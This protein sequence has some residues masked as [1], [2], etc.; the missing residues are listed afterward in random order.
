MSKSNNYVFGESEIDKE[1][2]AKN[3]GIICQRCNGTGTDPDYKEVNVILSAI[4]DLEEQDKKKSSNSAKPLNRIPLC[5]SCY[6]MVKI[7]W[8]DYVSGNYKQELL[9]LKNDTIKWFLLDADPFLQYIQ[10]GEVCYN[11]SGKKVHFDLERK[12]WIEVNDFNENID[13]YRAAYKWLRRFEADGY[14]YCSYN[15]LPYEPEGLCDVGVTMGWL[16]EL[17]TELIIS[18]RITIER[19]IEIKNDLDFFRHDIQDL[20]QFYVI[21]IVSKALPDGFK[22]TWENILRKYDLPLSYLHL[23]ESDEGKSAK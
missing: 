13:S 5:L 19:L 10:K 23:F 22:F 1:Q 12:L 18:Q 2:L 16:Q 21:D 9:D 3:F 6:G 7:D 11:K 20:D 8:V 15:D 4:Y 14:L 17:K